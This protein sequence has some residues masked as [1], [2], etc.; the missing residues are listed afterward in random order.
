MSLRRE[1]NTLNL[2]V[3]V[4]NVHVSDLVLNRIKQK[5]I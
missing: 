5:A 1:E 4:E 3:L 2:S